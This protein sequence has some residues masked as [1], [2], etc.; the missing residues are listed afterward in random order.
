MVY[1]VSKGGVWFQHEKNLT[2]CCDPLCFL[3]LHKIATAAY[4]TTSCDLIF[5]KKKTL[6]C[7]CI[8]KKKIY[9]YDYPT[10]ILY[11]ICAQK[12]H[13]QI[14]G[15]SAY[16]LMWPHRS[17]HTYKNN[18]PR[19]DWHISLYTAPRRSLVFFCWKKSPRWREK[20]NAQH[21]HLCSCMEKLWYQRSPHG[22]L[23]QGV[24]LSDVMQNANK[25]LQPSLTRGS[26]KC[27]NLTICYAEK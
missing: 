17:K 2:I 27:G 5:P 18:S 1:Y 26:W 12:L 9:I 6:V 14:H 13:I 15:H 3:F 16:I 11:K 7:W 8:Y 22:Y 23:W 10:F 21:T 19:R 4:V 24:A 20:K 25:Q